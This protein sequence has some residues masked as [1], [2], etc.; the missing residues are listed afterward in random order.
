MNGQRGEHKA[1]SPASENKN[2]G[3]LVKSDHQTNPMHTGT[4][5]RHRGSV[6]DHCNKASVAIT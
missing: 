5:Q 6:P 1:G 2:T 3:P 4:P